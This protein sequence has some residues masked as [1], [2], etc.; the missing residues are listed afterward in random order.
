MGAIRAEMAFVELY[1]ALESKAIDG[2][3]DPVGA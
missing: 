1:G 2:Q 3:D